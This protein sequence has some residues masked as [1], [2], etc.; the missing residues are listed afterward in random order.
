MLW[1]DVVDDGQP[2]VGGGTPSTRAS[3]WRVQWASTWR[4]AKAKL[5]R[6][7]H[8][9]Q[10]GAAPPWSRRRAGELAIG[11]VMP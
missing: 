11:H 2:G 9:S 8:G 10:I 5:A 1:A 4:L 7:A 6:G 3:A